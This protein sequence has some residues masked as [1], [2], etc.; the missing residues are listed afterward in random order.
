MGKVYGEYRSWL[1]GY[2]VMLDD[3]AEGSYQGYTSTV[4]CTLLYDLVRYNDNHIIL[5]SIYLTRVM[6]CDHNLSTI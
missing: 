1:S 2:R 5:T 4:S 6:Q 3:K